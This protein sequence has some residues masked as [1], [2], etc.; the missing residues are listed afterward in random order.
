MEIAT[1]AM[2]LRNDGYLF[3][4]FGRVYRK[5]SIFVIHI[6]LI[7]IELPHRFMKR[8]YTPLGRYIMRV[9]TCRSV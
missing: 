2:L 4:D 1:V 9:L 5:M 6:R 7:A 8:R 3:F